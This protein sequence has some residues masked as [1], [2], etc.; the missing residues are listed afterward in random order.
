M[1]WLLAT[2]ALAWD[3]EPTAA[4]ASHSITG[5][6]AGVVDSQDRVVALGVGTLS[7]HD[8]AGGGE[9]VSAPV[10]GRALTLAD[11][12]DDG[13]LD[14]VTCGVD[15]LI[16]VPLT[17][18]TIGTPR[19]VD[20]RGCTAVDT[21][22][23]GGVI[24]V[25]ADG[26][27]EFSPTSGGL[28]AGVDTGQ[29]WI[30]AE[31]LASNGA[32][33][34]AAREGETTW[35]SSADGTA[36][37]LGT[38]GVIGLAPSSTGF[39]LT[40][41]DGYERSDATGFVELGD[42]G[43]AASADIDGDGVLDL[44]TLRWQAH[45]A[46]VRGSVDDRERGFPAGGAELIS[47]ANLV[48]GDCGSV[49]IAA[50]RAYTLFTAVGCRGDADGDG[51]T[52]EDGDCDDGDASVYPG[53]AELC[54]EVDHDCSG[55]PSD[56]PVVIDLASAA[57]EGSFIDGSIEFCSLD[58]RNPDITSTP[59]DTS[60]GGSGGA[61][62]C[63]VGGSDR[64]TLRVW[65]PGDEA[66][67]AEHVVAIT[68]LPPTLAA[69]SA[70]FVPGEDNRVPLEVFDAGNDAVTCSLIDGPSWLAISSDCV[71]S[72]SPSRKRDWDVIVRLEDSD[73]GV[74]DAPL[75]VTSEEGGGGGCGGGGGGGCGGPD[76]SPDCSPD[77]SCNNAVFIP[78][79]Y[80]GVLLFLSWRRRKQQLQERIERRRADAPDDEDRP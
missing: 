39:W 47:A 6:Q 17:A 19:V 32:G 80:T 21:L 41:A 8:P 34:A 65:M 62:Q 26:I 43:P 66:N 76:C 78:I 27:F 59:D 73:G 44:I 77:I 4:T 45:E 30:G 22:P 20:A 60:C 29:A 48:P 12:D 23:G 57:D 79:G 53:A 55:S 24:A 36:T 71:A 42:G 31:L 3:L 13:R 10:A 38:S 28:A 63:S 35:M 69:P 33:F 67:A 1:L 74:T 52:T 14:A 9:L 16:E 18:S 51:V 5:I 75:H 2:V 7:L 11:V 72:G 49:V 37:T 56:L 68:N 64:M 54:D 15:G 50:D 61:L 25:F 40:H 70:F 46:V 58:G